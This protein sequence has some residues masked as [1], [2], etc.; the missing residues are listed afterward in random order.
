MNANDIYNMGIE[1]FNSLFENL[2][3]NGCIISLDCT[4]REYCRVITQ[5]YA[6]ADG[7]Y[8]KCTGTDI[9]KDTSRINYYGICMEQGKNKS[10]IKQYKTLPGAI[11]LQ[12]NISTAYKIKFKDCV[13]YLL[14]GG[15]YDK[16]K[17]RTITVKSFTGNIANKEYLSKIHHTAKKMSTNDFVEWARNAQLAKE[18]EHSQESDQ[19][20]QSILAD[21]LSDTGFN[22]ILDKLIHN[23]IQDNS[24]LMNKLVDKTINA[25]Y[26][27]N[28]KY[29]FKPYNTEKIKNRTFEIY[30]PELIKE[31]SKI[32]DED[33]K[34]L[35]IGES[36]S[37]K[38]RLA[39][40][41]AQRLTGKIIDSESVD[42]RYQ[43]V[44]IKN[45]DGEML[46]Y[47]GQDSNI[48]GN[49]NVFV[50]HIEK[51]N[52]PNQKYVFILNEIQRTDLGAISGNLFESWSSGLI[53]DDIP[54]N[55]YIIFTACSNSDF[56]LDDQIFQRIRYVELD[57]LRSDNKDLITNLT[58]ILYS[59]LFNLEVGKCTDIISLSQELNDIEEYQV[60][61]MRHLFAMFNG[62]TIKNPINKED[63][64]SQ[65]QK[66]LQEMI[67]KGY[68]IT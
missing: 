12:K 4:L 50:N 1:K 31:A 48:F 19:A 49:L 68:Y 5:L 13:A 59:N 44:W 64:T 14:K 6:E 2:N 46:W 7:D 20:Q 39:T 21:G 51:E 38:S 45:V 26:E 25:Q 23:L 33:H 66:K 15:D 28:L 62:R 34:L 36:G 18:A 3:D 57:Y 55:L 56:E 65:G 22:I 42:G 58:A 11:S 8:Y 27:R 10:G 52:N 30:N 41:L 67:N 43:H 37:G 47:T 40:C 29:K 9:F 32:L 61:N 53:P 54:D 63:L 24:P 17:P 60:I 35:I 16:V